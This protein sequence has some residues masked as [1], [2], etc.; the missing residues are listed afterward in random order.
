ML[1]EGGVDDADVEENLAGFSNLLELF[2]SIVKF[3]VVV[4]SQGSN[5][6]LDLL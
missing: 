5:P 4:S 3:V 6:G 2:D 1:A